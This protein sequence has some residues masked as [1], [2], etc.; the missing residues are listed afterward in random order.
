MPPGTTQAINKKNSA[1]IFKE[2]LKA[3]CGLA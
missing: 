1:D 3:E 2:L